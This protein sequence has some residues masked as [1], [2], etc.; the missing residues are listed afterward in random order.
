MCGLAQAQ[1]GSLVGQ[2]RELIET[3][4]RILALHE[5]RGSAAAG[6]D[7]EARTRAGQ[8]LFHGMQ[9][10]TLALAQGLAAAS[11]ANDNAALNAFLDYAERGD[12]F[13]VDRLALR[14]ALEE[15]AASQPAGPAQAR[16]ARLQAEMARIQSRYGRELAAAM[17]EQPTRG[18]SAKRASWDEYLGFL[19]EKYPADE[20]LRTLENDLQD[21]T[22]GKPSRAP[23]KEA[24]AMSDEINGGNLPAKTLLLTFDDGPHP[25]YTDQI[26]AI[27]ARYKVKALFFQVGQNLGTTKDQKVALAR[28]AEVD[29]R[30]L[31]AGH[32][33]ANHTY[34]HPFLPKLDDKRLVEEIDSTQQLLLAAVPEGPGRTAMFRA[35]YGARNPQVLSELAD[36]KLRSVMWN[37]DSR[38][39][40]DPVPDSIAKRVVA[41]VDKEGRGIILFH[42]IHARTVEALPQVL[43]AL[44]A[45]GYKFAAWNGKELV[46]ENAALPAPASEPLYRESY[47][48]VIGIDEYAAW[49]KLRYAVNDARAIRDTLV[50]KYGFKPQNVTLLANKEATRENIIA[51]LGTSMADTRKVR[52]EDRVFVFFAGHGATRRLPSG[53]DLG[54][55]IPVDASAENYQTQAISMT[56]LQD[57]AEAIPAKH[58]LFI[59]D[60][61]YSGLALTRG[62]VDGNIYARELARRGARQ[63]FTAGGADEQ[64]A[65]NGPNGHSIFTWTLLQGLQGKADLNGD[66][67]ITASELAAHV[68]PVVSTLSRQTPAFGNLVGSEGGDMIFETG[69]A[70][71]YLSGES[72]QLDDEATRLAEQ[73]AKLKGEIAAKADRNAKLRA[74]LASL[75]A[76]QGPQAAQSGAPATTPSPPV[77]PPS[78][79]MTASA[80][81]DRGTNLFREKQ[82][83]E[84]QAEFE[85]AVKADPNFALAANN[86][87]YTHY[88]LERFPLAAQWFEKTIQLDPKRA[89]AY[90]NLGDVYVKLN[91]RPEAKRAYEK[92]LEL[93][94]TG[95]GADAARVALKGL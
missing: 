77:L 39:W 34:S 87:G 27:L 8:Y 24:R 70:N 5:E 2:A 54:Y 42:D 10:K 76:G 32:A 53:R 88:R 29:K 91:K 19:H 89:V 93:A 65:D 28:N 63:M 21:G 66:G 37:I 6:V 80:H 59:M 41:E 74:E 13:D 55:I 14:D 15:W 25:R 81:N 33:I 49:P 62:R 78:G 57:I 73:I 22:R 90:L 67:V 94:P 83:A 44:I 12:L 38:D 20:I 11:R 52:R 71:E 50:E 56:Q 26:L 61:C 86:L 4:R 40:A 17:A 75:Q 82:Y 51:A 3:Q 9:Q 36:R 30:I 72:R 23:E 60:S 69:H 46:V 79:P 18:L 92:Y 84:A 1:T 48:V 7:A 85:A 16:L 35:P 43:D 45:K 58:V 68:S 31:A 47:A 64:V 95:R